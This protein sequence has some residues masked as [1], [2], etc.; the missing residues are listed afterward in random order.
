MNPDQ[1]TSVRPGESLDES[2]LLTYLHD[3]SN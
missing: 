2:V 1:A 3:T